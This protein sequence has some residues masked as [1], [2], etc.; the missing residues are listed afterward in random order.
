MRYVQFAKFLL[1]NWQV[2]PPLERLS[3]EE[4]TRMDLVV[5]HSIIH[6][7]YGSM[8]KDGMLMAEAANF[9]INNLMKCLRFHAASFLNAAKLVLK[10]LRELYT[11]HSS[12]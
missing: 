4:E 10:N 1:K 9:F 12:V 5:S 8:E 6:V 11:P 7:M 2:L 3:K